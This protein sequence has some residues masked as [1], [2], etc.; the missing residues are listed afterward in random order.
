MR[1]F[2]GRSLRGE[3]DD[4]TEN[5]EASALQSS[6]LEA[7]DPRFGFQLLFQ[8]TDNAFFFA[9]DLA[10]RILF[11]NDQLISHYGFKS[12]EEFIGKTDYDFLPRS[13]AEKYSRDDRTIVRTGTPM[14][15]ILELFLDDAGVPD[16]YFTTKYPLVA[17]DGGILGVMGIVQKFGSGNRRFFVDRKLGTIMDYMWEHFSENLQARKLAELGNMTVRQLQ[18]LFKTKL[19][20]N[21]RDMIVKIR[22]LKACDLLRLTDSHLSAIAMDCGFYDQS[23]FSRHFKRQMGITPRQYRANY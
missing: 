9:K 20:S 10:G 11:A 1:R 2:L 17:R 18:R 4:M 12:P 15:R 21:P 3:L 16:W 19:N 7:I 13:I 5:A 23:D 8:Y 14:V 6:L 22:V